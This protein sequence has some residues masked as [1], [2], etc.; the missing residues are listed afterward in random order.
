MWAALSERA[1]HV[2]W[3]IGQHPLEGGSDHDVLLPVGIT[4]AL[5][6]HW[7]DRFM[8]TNFDTPDKVSALEMENVALSHGMAALLMAAGAAEHAYALLA[9]L[10]HVASVKLRLEI[11]ATDRLLA[12]LER[13]PI[14]GVDEPTVAERR[15]VEEFLLS[16]WARWYD[17]AL[18][19]LME[20]PTGENTGT[21]EAAIDSARAR[22]RAQSVRK[23]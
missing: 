18:G 15:P 2:D 16:E 1:R 22:V 20:L 8:G 4:T 6:W 9:E 13:G 11:E 17:Q 12:D 10:E 3:T 14:D 19:S 23:N 5:S 7:P 21:L